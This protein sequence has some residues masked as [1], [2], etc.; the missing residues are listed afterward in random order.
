[1]KKALLYFVLGI[2]LI[3]GISL[4]RNQHTDAKRDIAS[5][6]SSNYEK[7]I[8]ILQKIPLF[9]DYEVRSSE[10]EKTTQKLIKIF[11]SIEDESKTEGKL[12][13]G[14]HVKGSCFAGSFTVFSREELNAKFKYDDSLI[15][16]LKSGIFAHDG[17]Y[18]AQ[19]RFAN[20]KGERNPDTKADVRGFSFSVDLPGKVTDHTGESRQDFM[21]NS[22]PMFAVKNIH[23]FLQ[24][25]KAA[26]F[27]AG[28]FT[29][30]TTEFTTV[31]H[32][33]KLLAEYERNDTLSFATEEYWG[34]LPYSHGLNQA[35]SPANV[36]KYKATPC[37]GQGARHESSADK[38]SDYLQKDIASRAAEGKVCFLIQVQ[39]F[40]IEKL[41][42]VH[43]GAA[44][45]WE[46]SDWIE[47]GGMLWDEKILP[48][49][50]LAQVEIKPSTDSQS[51]CDTQYLNTRLH[52]NAE[53]QPIGS[54]A[55]V[56]TFV[57]ENS[58]ARRM[59][60]LP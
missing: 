49:Y 50:T 6:T 38:E 29:S 21:M 5:P 10:E 2:I 23:D 7:R 57:E 48:F 59:G 37:D 45:N 14:T 30:I 39:F 19:L 1:M 52:S 16:N 4:F 53:N 58:R 56:R 42:S 40:D 20:A 8:Q 51:S 43:T 9:K 15:N 41:R 11:K 34:N 17:T 46:V 32:A 55:R 25:M 54:I 47:N 13:R 27:A 60:E 35:G 26:R 24:L 36:V 3:G 12:N 33:L 31:G 44:P 22:T 28:D 18:K